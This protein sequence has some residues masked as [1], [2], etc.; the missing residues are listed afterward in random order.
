MLLAFGILC[1]LGLSIVFW[2]WLETRLRQ[3]NRHSIKISKPLPRPLKILHL[4]D[5]HFAGPDR[6]L[7]SFFDRLAQETYDLIVMSGD[8]FDCEKGILRA[9]E[10]LSK[11][12]S[13][14][15][16]HAVLG[17]HDYFDYRFWDIFKPGIR[18]RGYPKIAQPVEQFMECLKRVGVKVFRN[19]HLEIPFENTTLALHGL[20]DPTTG[21]ADIEKAMRGYDPEHINI[22]LTHTID[23]F[24]YIGE[25][26]IDLSFSGHSHGGQIRF[27]WFGA[28]ITHTDFGPKYSQGIH[29]LKGAVCS[30]SRGVSASRFFSLRL[31]CPP[32]AIVLTVEGN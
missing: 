15:G 14:F 32:E 24:F 31:L 18:G 28:L 21:Q 12:K 9:K 17:N 4:S 6:G 8:I 25:N 30:V 10:N 20:D 16:I 26:E 11:L 3:I 2:T 13:K 19:E 29:P 22:L 7:T 23:A 27:P 1:L 5:I